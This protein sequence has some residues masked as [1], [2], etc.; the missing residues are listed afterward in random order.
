MA[1]LQPRLFSV[2]HTKRPSVLLCNGT[3]KVCFWSTPSYSRVLFVESLL[4][5]ASCDYRL[6]LANVSSVHA[7]IYQQ[8]C[9]RRAPRRAPPPVQELLLWI[10]RR[11]NPSIPPS[12][13]YEGLSLR[14]SSERRS[15]AWR[16]H[17]PVPN[18]RK[19]A[20]V[21]C[22]YP[23]GGQRAPVRR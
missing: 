15:P 20:C 8:P 11:P 12:V 19:A 4:F 5:L 21:C 3:W 16:L 14:V 7:A 18:K 22:V 2:I 6:P 9:R 17:P 10:P 1:T 13:T 23:V